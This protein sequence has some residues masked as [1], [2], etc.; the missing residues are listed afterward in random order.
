ARRCSPEA[1]LTDHPTRGGYQRPP[2]GD[3]LRRDQL[4]IP[5]PGKLE[6]GMHAARG[7]SLSSSVVTTLVV[8]TLH[9][10]FLVVLPITA[11]LGTVFAVKAVHGFKTARVE[12]ARTEALRSVAGYLNQARVDANRAVQNILRHNRAQIRDYYLDRAT[13]LM[14]TAQ[15]EQAAAVRAAQVDRQSAPPRASQTASDLARVTTL[16]D[17]AGRVV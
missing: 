15:A 5:G 4:S 1:A 14:M 12:A 2:P 10:G 3:G 8:A 16:L 11:A 13:E 17:A 6:L 9:P 7:W